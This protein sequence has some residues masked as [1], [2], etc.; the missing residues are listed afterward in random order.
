MTN[1]SYRRPENDLLW[2][3]GLVGT[4]DDLLVTYSLQIAT[5]GNRRSICLTADH[6]VHDAYV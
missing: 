6:I 5:I 1:K 3:R 2:V 4:V